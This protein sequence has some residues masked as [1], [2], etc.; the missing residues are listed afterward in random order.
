MVLERKMEQC[1]RIETL[2]LTVYERLLHPFPSE[3]SHLGF[4]RACSTAGSFKSSAKFGSAKTALQI[5]QNL[6]WAMLG[7]KTRYA[8]YI[9]LH[10]FDAFLWRASSLFAFF[11]FSSFASFL[12][13]C[14]NS[15]LSEC[16]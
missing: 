4:G 10:L 1:W 2:L 9:P 6:L 12:S 13:T 8:V 5:G 15:I 16:M 7:K 3:S 11:F 14:F